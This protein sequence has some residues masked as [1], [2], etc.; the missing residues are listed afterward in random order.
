MAQLQSKINSCSRRFFPN[1]PLP[2]TPFLTPG[3]LLEDVLLH[4]TI[5]YVPLNSHL[6]HL[7]FRGWT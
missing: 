2:H 5:P 4:M 1:Y 3:T 7:K 6:L